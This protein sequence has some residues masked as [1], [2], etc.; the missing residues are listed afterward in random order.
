MDH[1]QHWRLVQ[2]ERGQRLLRRLTGWLSTLA[3][4]VAVVLGVLFAHQGRSVAGTHAPTGG[5]SVQQQDSQG[6]ERQ[7]DGTGSGG[8]STDPG[9]QPPAQPPAN[10]GGGGPVIQSGG[11]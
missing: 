11:S 6:N 7:D 3:V 2:R 4:S 9:L 10:S 5:A 1:G 8:V